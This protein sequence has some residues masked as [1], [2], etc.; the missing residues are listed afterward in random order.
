MATLGAFGAVRVAAGAASAGVGEAL[1]A[2]VVMVVA[3][4]AE[5]ADGA[6]SGWD[7]ARTGCAGAVPARP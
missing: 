5:A 6:T 4:C 7:V 3:A 1:A 2:G